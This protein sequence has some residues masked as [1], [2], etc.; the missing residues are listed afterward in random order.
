MAEAPEFDWDEANVEHIARHR[1]TREEVEQVFKNGIADI[2]FQS[3]GDEERTVCLGHT[4]CLHRATGN[5]SG[6]GGFS[7]EPEVQEG[8]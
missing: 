4:G 7:D 6:G 8:L 5:D 2:D 3:H 1:I